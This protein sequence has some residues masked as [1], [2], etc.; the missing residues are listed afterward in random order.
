MSTPT[1]QESAQPKATEVAT[2][3]P[4]NE[5]VQPTPPAPPPVPMTGQLQLN[6]DAPGARVWLDGE[7]IGQASPS[8]PL[9]KEGLS[10]GS[11]RIRIE[12]EGRQPWEGPVEI[13]RGQWQQIAAQLKPVEEAKEYRDPASGMEFIKIDGGSFQM[14]SPSGEKDRGSDEGQ[15]LVSVGSFYLGRTEVTNAQYRRYKPGHDSGDYKGK[16]L[17]GDNQP[18][19]NVSWEEATAYAEW[20]SRKAGKNYR[21]PT[22]AEWEYAARA[23][24]TGP[25]STGNCI[26][27]AQA[28][29][30]GNYD[31]NDC[32]AKTGT[33]RQKTLPVGSL[34]ANPWGLYDMHGNVWEWTC[35]AYDEGYG[36][37]EKQCSSKNNASSSRA[38]RGGSWSNGPWNVCSAARDGDS[39]GSR[40]LNIGFRLLQD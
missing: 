33:Y 26:N 28:N 18:V 12:A 27:T 17:N 25:F 2:T 1:A 38:L 22:E 20:L 32:G 39:P 30:N 7:A 36:G 23:G 13:S 6:V 19:V 11:H 8:S 3:Q 29:Y 10:T 40:T 4:R 31:Y 14:G 16:S 37:S 5:P 24:T 21:L 15:H 34:K 35:S 9:N